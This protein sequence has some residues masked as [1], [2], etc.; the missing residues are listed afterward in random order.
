M[1]RKRLLVKGLVQGVGFRPF[2]FRL[3]E[4]HGLSGF[5]RN[6]PDGVVIEI[7]GPQDKIPD[8]ISELN[9]DKPKSSR[10]NAIHEGDMEVIPSTKHTFS[11]LESRTG[12][13]DTTI[14]VDIST[15]PACLG[16]ILDPDNRRYLYPFT[17]CSDCGPR[18]SILEAIPYDRE[19]TTMS[20]FEMC[21]QCENEYKDPSDRR[22]HAQNN[23]CPDCG[24]M[25][26]LT[27]KGRNVI[28]KGNDTYPEVARLLKEGNIIA[29]KGTG[30][31]Q[32]WADARNNDAIE[33]LRKRKNRP[34]KPFAVMFSSVEEIKKY[35]NVN[36][37]EEYILTSPATPIVLLKRKTDT[38]LSSFVA[39]SNP[40]LGAMLPANPLQSI[41]LKYWGAPVIAT[42][43][44]L[45][46]EPICINNDEVFDR[47]REIA[48]YVLI[49][50]REIL[51][52]LD[53]S[54]VHVI[55][56]NA[57]LLRV[58]RGYAPV[59]LTLPEFIQNEEEIIAFGGD[60]K[61]AISVCTG[62]RIYLGQ[63]LGD[64]ADPVSLNNLEQSSQD[65]SSLCG[66]DI[67]AALLISDKHP[68]YFSSKLAGERAQK[69][70]LKHEQIQ[71]HQ[72]HA[73]AAWLDA[74]S[75]DSCIVLAWDGTGSGDDGTLW[76]SEFFSLNTD[77][78]GKIQINRITSLNSFPLPGGETAITDIRRSLI[79]LLWSYELLPLFEK[80]L[81]SMFSDTELAAIKNALEKKINT[82]LSSGM[83]RLFDAISALLNLSSTSSFEGEAAMALE[84]AA[85]E[86]PLITG[87]N[88]SMSYDKGGI[89]IKDILKQIHDDTENN[90]SNADIAKKFHN[91]LV[92]LSLHVINNHKGNRNVLL[93]GGVFQ[94]RLLT[95]LMLKKLKNNGY[96]VHIHSKIPPNDG[97]I[98]VGQVVA[99]LCV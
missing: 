47:L 59:E 32:L 92:D 72:A 15:C 40:Y 17:H 43:S 4:K 27:D 53:D 23:A 33:L 77:D 49:H 18:Y 90:V 51:Y 79:G 81:K 63:H 97:G 73:L 48:D 84:Y 93:T 46:G 82:P 20:R 61:G 62:K 41:L 35:C 22:F 94:N 56:D 7:Q 74:A 8:F 36:K 16:E 71:H 86:S 24:P 78:K 1:I 12:Q 37:T 83:G 44:N 42:S 89:A 45:S 66:I 55:N 29:V 64:L 34:T 98:S 58:G 9:T 57:Q 87:Y 85:M 38:G 70:E 30:G 2:V 95:E 10:I 11:I 91:S 50:N 80:R 75:P 39:P 21:W 3:A 13:N 99:S 28:C 54:I 31:F 14:P 69:Y 52:P 6:T 60:I 26:T 5:I 96:N 65:L 68:A 25:I 19:R 88:L 76:G 67:N